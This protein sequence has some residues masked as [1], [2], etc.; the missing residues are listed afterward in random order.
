MLLQELLGCE[1]AG[2]MCVFAAAHPQRFLQKQPD[3]MYLPSEVMELDLRGRL[4]VAKKGGFADIDMGE[5]KS[6][7]DY[8]KAV[9]RLGLRLG[10]LRWLVCA[11]CGVADAQVKLVGRLFVPEYTLG[12]QY[13][14]DQQQDMALH[15][16]GYSLYV[17]GF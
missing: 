16:W 7:V 12:S 10:V 3:R 6:S 2:L 5:I 9:E 4:H 17:H 14:D 13:V 1:G 8:A 15:V 11:C